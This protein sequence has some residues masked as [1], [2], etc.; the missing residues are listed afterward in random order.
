MDKSGPDIAE[1][2]KFYVPLAAT[3]MLM[4]V[5]HSVISAAVART[6]TPALSLAAYSAAYSVGQVFESPCYG[7]QR[8]GLTFLRGKQSSR[9][10]L[11]VGLMMLAFIVCAYGA[12]AF[13]PLAEKVFKG[14]LGVSQDIFPKALA[15]LQVFILW[16]VFSALR[17]L[18]Q[19]KIV[20]AKRTAWLT[21]NMAVR[22]AVMLGI[23]TVLPRILPG[24]PV[25]AVILVSGIGTEAVLALL[26]AR[27][28]VPPLEDDPAD[29]PL[30]SARDVLAFALPL[31]LAASVQTLGR[32]VL[33]AALLRGAN[34]TVTLAGYQVASS[35][36]YIFTALTYNIYHAV[37]VFVKDRVSYVRMRAFCLGLGV[38]GSLLL[39]L[40]S[41]PAV[42][43]FVFG[44]L[45]GAPPDVVEEAV[46]TIAVLSLLPLSSAAMEFCSGILMQKKRARIVTFAKIVNVAATCS[47][48]MVLVALFPRIGGVAGA[49][50]LVLGPFVEAGLSY[51]FMTRAP[52]CRELVSAVPEL[53]TQQEV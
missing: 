40:S 5:T 34:P 39:V 22:V 50:A 2:L 27:R 16:P 48:A 20:L 51:R 33:T 35:F 53:K 11:R 29:E 28:F 12:V 19:P 24:G 10:V 30:V 25:G 23:A 8:M 32:P 45:I 47:T 43:R 38:L 13:T 7:M 42:G 44:V 26:V 1:V 37:V 15:S 18:F 36:S 9:T 14:L 17:S 41:I 31:A 3:S 4:M 52:E 49:A 6:L 21:V 46:R